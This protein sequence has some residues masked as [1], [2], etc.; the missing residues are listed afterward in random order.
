MPELSC[1][2]KVAT[3]CHPKWVIC[4]LTACIDYSTAN[5]YFY[6]FNLIEDKQ[7]LLLIKAIEHHNLIKGR[8]GLIAVL[9]LWHLQ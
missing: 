9:I 8:I 5:S 1:I 7:T 3:I 4:H 6:L 2:D